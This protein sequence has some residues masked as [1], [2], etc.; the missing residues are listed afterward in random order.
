[1][2]TFFFRLMKIVNKKE[3][4]ILMT[5]VQN[6]LY[7]SVEYKGTLENGEVFDTSEGRQPL[8]IQMG[9]GQLISGFENQLMGM[10]LNEKKTFTLEPEEAYGEKKEG[11]TQSFEK[12]QLPPD[13]NL[14][15]GQM[16]ALQ[17]QEGQHVPATVIG[18]TDKEFVVDVNHPLAGKKLT[19]EIEI[20]GISEAPQQKQES[21][22]CG[23]D[24]SS[25]SC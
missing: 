24:C 15:M 23:C 4:E 22:G 20:V 3:L 14:E 25:G 7:V 6:D 1:M 11:L 9:A 16:I 8:E 18:I 13:V 19:F 17:T 21:C 12:S 10:S 2:L 5:K